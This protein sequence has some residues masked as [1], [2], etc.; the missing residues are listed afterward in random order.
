MY[1]LYILNKEAITMKAIV[2]KTE[3]KKIYE[4]QTFPL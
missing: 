3:E 2:T 4:D 1:T